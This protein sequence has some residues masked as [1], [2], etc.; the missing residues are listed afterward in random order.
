ML[1]ETKREYVEEESDV[2]NHLLSNI[3][4]NKSTIMNSGAGSGKTYAL[5]QCLK[6]VVSKYGNSL[7]NNNQHVICIT[8]TNVAA[9]EIK[10]RLGNTDIIYVSTIHERLWD[11][12]RPYKKELVKIHIGNLNNKIYEIETDLDTNSKFTTYQNLT[13]EGKQAFV[14]IMLNEANKATFYDLYDFRAPEFRSSIKESIDI[15]DDML[16]NVNNF[17]SLVN[18]IYKREKYKKCIKE[19]EDRGIDKFEVTYDARYNT[20]RLEYFTIS[21][22]TLLN[23]SKVMIEQYDKLKDI[24]IDT[25]PYIFVDEYQDTNKKVIEILSSIEERSKNSG[26]NHSFF[27]GYF[28]DSVQNIYND[29]VG[30]EIF[31]LHPSCEIVNKRFNRRSC[32]EVIKVA[33]AI[34]KDEIEQ[35][36]IYEDCAGGSVEFY[37][38]SKD[39]ID[40]FISRFKDEFVGQSSDKLHCF[41]LTNESVANYSGIENIYN[42]FKKTDY[43]RKH[44]EQLTTE[45]LSNEPEKLGTIP[46]LIYRLIEFWVLI[47]NDKTPIYSVFDKSMCQD[48]NIEELRDILNCIRNITASNLYE[49]ISELC[50][51]YSNNEVSNHQVYSSLIKKLF[52]TDEISIP[53]IKHYFCENLFK[54]EGEGD[55]GKVIESI[56]EIFNI[57]LDEYIKWY[58]Y[59]N[60]NDSGEVIYHTYH[61]TKGLEFEN[62]LIIMGNSFGRKTDFFNVFFSNYNNENNLDNITKKTFISAKNLLYVSITR[63]IKNLR[64][65]YTDPVNDFEN[66]LKLIFNNIEKFNN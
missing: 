14:E 9:N 13:A 27:V 33:N 5:I 28:G 48:L 23:Y 54:N 58:N 57:S 21:H 47:K 30:P 24:I 66:N 45:L 32:E 15:N 39:N 31:E 61:G 22:D 56:N 6:H 42:A 64:I 16:N 34:R 52:N 11:I 46:S 59:I 10:E 18:K 2:L 1:E 63:A 38:G 25:Y 40:D 20:D 3:E 17:K 7:K 19:T 12:I 49:L 36:S 43:Y 53:T 65:L 8:Y 35:V 41:M 62:V 55:D 50:S 4:C 37:R 44:Y 26:R 29:G 51:I 60:K